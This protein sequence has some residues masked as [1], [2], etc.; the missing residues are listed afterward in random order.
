MENKRTT[1]TSSQN[2][3]CWNH[4]NTSC[5]KS[6][7]TSMTVKTTWI[8]FFRRID[9]Q[10]EQHTQLVIQIFDIR[11]S[12]KLWTE[13]SRSLVQFAKNVNYKKTD[14]QSNVAKR[15]R[16]AKTEC[17]AHFAMPILVNNYNLSAIFISMPHVFHLSAFVRINI[18]GE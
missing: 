1:N 13:W 10:S 2:S 7:T 3:D 12:Y 14:R 5:V 17:S 18:I 15:R 16:A 9:H 6:T 8:P 11:F 4:P